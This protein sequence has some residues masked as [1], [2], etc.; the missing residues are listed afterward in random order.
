SGPLRSVADGQ[1][2]VYGAAAGV[3][4]AQSFNSTNYFVDLQVSSSAPTATALS[5][6]AGSSGVSVG[7]RP[8]ATFSRAMDPATIT[9]ASFTLSGPA[10]AVAATVAYDAATNSATLTP[11][12]PLAMS[13]TYTAALDATVKAADGVALAAP[14]SWSFTTQNAAP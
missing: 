3:F 6:A 12:A 10:G 8:S 14:V 5:P 4:P 2:G 7:V 11:A 9:S 1:N 13:T